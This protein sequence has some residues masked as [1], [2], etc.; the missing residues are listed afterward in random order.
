MKY[1]TA[2]NVTLMYENNDSDIV[3]TIQLRCNCT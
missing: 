2:K 1:K 3:D